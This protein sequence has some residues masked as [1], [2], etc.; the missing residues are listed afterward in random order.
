[1][2]A[3][4]RARRTLSEPPTKRTPVLLSAGGNAKDTPLAE[5]TDHSKVPVPVARAYTKPSLEAAKTVVP[6]PERQ[7][8]AD[9]GLRV[10]KLHTRLPVDRLTLYTLLS[11]QPAYTRAKSR[12]GDVNRLLEAVNIHC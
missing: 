5:K 10:K 6:S 1:M 12:L 7:S 2:L 3:V 11:A 9:T 8:G 4:E